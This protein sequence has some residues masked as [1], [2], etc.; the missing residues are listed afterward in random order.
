MRYSAT[1]ISGRRTVGLVEQD[2]SSDVRQVA[3]TVDGNRLADLPLSRHYAPA[4]AVSDDHLAV[5]GGTRLHTVSLKDNGL[6]TSE[7]ED[8]VLAAYFVE[9][10]WCLVCETSVVTLDGSH[11][12]VFKFEHDEVLSSCWWVGDELIV[13][14]FQGRKLTLSKSML[15]P[16]AQPFR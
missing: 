15:A 10:K 13:V 5:W 4:V 3:L 1:F 16:P 9:D 6:R 12:V 14:D 11:N 8:E 2:A 7:L